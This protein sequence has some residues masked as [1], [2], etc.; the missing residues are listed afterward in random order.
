LAGRVILQ[1][2]SLAALAVSASHPDGH[3]FVLVCDDVHA[4]FI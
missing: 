1:P 3:D 4:E 2:V